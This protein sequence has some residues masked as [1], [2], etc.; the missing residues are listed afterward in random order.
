MNGTSIYITFRLLEMRRDGCND[1]PLTNNRSTSSTW[2]HKHLEIL[3]YFFE[4]TTV[5][6]TMNGRSAKDPDKMKFGL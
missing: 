3:K 5:Q 4:S 1:V 6:T 2:K